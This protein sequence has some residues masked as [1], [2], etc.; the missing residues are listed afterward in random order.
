MK[1]ILGVIVSLFAIQS[2]AISIPIKRLPVTLDPQ[3]YDDI[4][5]MVAILQVHR[6]LMKFKPN[7][8]IENDLADS[9]KI[10]DDGKVIRFKL[11]ERTFSNGA[12]ILARHVVH[13]LRRLFKDKSG[14]SADLNYIV[15]AKNILKGF[16]KIESLGV[17]ALDNKTV[18][19]RLE[20]PVGIFF[21]HLASVDLAI[22]PIDVDLDYDW[23][24]SV[25]AGPYFLKRF[26]NKKM[27][28]ERNSSVKSTAP[29]LI[30][31]I[32]MSDSEAIQAAL[33]SEIDSLD[34]FSVPVET[35]SRL[36][37]SGWKQS[38]TTM[39]R[40]LFLVINPQAVEKEV[41]SFIQ[42]KIMSMAFENVPA[43]YQRAY[44]VVPFGLAG[45]I[46]ENKLTQMTKKPEKMIYLNIDM[47]DA[48]PVI[49]VI[50][51]QI[52]KELKKINISFHIN[53]ISIEQYLE[54]IKS[55]KFDLMVRSKFLDYP[56]AISIL[57]YFRSK[58][59]SNT[60]FV[61]SKKVDDLLDRSMAELS[62]E[63][64]SRIYID[65]QNEILAQ[66]TVVPLVFGSDNLGLWSSKLN[67]VPAH[68]LGIQ[69]LPFEEL[70]SLG[71]K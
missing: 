44:G 54:K 41:R 45:S 63:K 4:Y 14:F 57:T 34:G 29:D 59:S 23:R 40:Q 11:G 49:G 22:L 24:K 36:K 26:D 21:A 13:T 1:L 9:Y 7:L 30:N 62:I 65:I 15:G 61:E 71:K 51:E 27:T 5:S 69:G 19:F 35:V 31:I 43:S 66:R 70:V 28:L 32:E 38:V 42:E 60:F 48:E 2:F 64:R 20:K 16:G 39:T 56:D 25:G 68:P 58:Y 18:E 47:V 53:K 10:F 6:G 33:K 55:K 46:S 8:E 17:V 3:N 52:R 50:L 67:S 12:P 37:E